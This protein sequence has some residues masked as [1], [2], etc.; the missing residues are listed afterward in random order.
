MKQSWIPQKQS[1]CFVRH[2]AIQVKLVQRPSRNAFLKKIQ[3][4]CGINMFRLWER[5]HNDVYIKN[6]PNSYT[7]VTCNGNL[8]ICLYYSIMETFTTGQIYL[9]VQLCEILKYPPLLIHVSILMSR[10]NSEIIQ[11]VRILITLKSI[12]AP[13]TMTRMVVKKVK[14]KSR[15]LPM[16]NH[17]L[18]I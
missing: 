17:L 9:I 11:I 8:V 7:V 18:K 5:Y 15:S 3:I 10:M 12:P 14:L 4:K 6:Y 1:L 16:A 2:Y 13:L